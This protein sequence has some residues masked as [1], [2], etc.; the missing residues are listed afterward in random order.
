MQNSV[1]NLQQQ[2]SQDIEKN[3]IL[4]YVKG[5]PDFPQCGF[6]KAVMEIFDRLG[7][8]YET[9]DVLEDP[10]LRDGIKQFTNW[11]TIP[12]VFIGGKFVGGCDIVRDLDS[13]GELEPM[14]KK[15][16]GQA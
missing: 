4:L 13:T 9:R 2:I 15:V 7:V 16:T 11:P 10:M 1:D 8:K 6:S 14:V 3:P 5:S 12:Q